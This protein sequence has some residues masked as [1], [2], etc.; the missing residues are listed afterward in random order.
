MKNKALCVMVAVFV[1]LTFSIANV[2][3]ARAASDDY[4]NVV[5]KILFTPLVTATK[6]VVGVVQLPA[7]M[8]CCSFF[9]GL[10]KVASRPEYVVEQVGLGLLNLVTPWNTRDYTN[11]FGEDAQLAVFAESIPL[12]NYGKWGV[13]TGGLIYGLGGGP[14]LA[15]VSHAGNWA[16]AT[17]IGAVSGA[18]FG[19][20]T[21]Y[22]RY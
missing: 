21:S 20:G 17:G 5:V 8:F 19:A 13:A 1:V 6:I 15:G 18:T 9:G 16:A 2:N 22:F 10:D 7:N 12:W 11:N 3:V 14:F 4:P